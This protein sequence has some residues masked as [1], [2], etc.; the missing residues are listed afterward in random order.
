MSFNRSILDWYSENKRNLPW[1]E[2]ADPYKIWVSE[3][4]LQQT[5]V[6]QGLAYYNRFINA[7]PNITSL[8]SAKEEAVLK[9]WQGLGYYSRA[10]N[11][12][13]TANVICSKHNGVFPKTSSSSILHL[14]SRI[15]GP[16][17]HSIFKILNMHG[18]CIH[19]SP[20]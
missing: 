3:I 8:A 1:R 10:R 11:M 20:C 17:L 7:Y 9:V 18:G 6:S 13:T 14:R 16:I 12:H 2:T 4:I 19:D 15:L 5:R